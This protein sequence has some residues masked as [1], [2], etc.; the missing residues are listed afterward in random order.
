VSITQDSLGRRATFH[1]RDEASSQSARDL[2]IPISCIGLRVGHPAYARTIVDVM[3]QPID[4]LRC[5][6]AHPLAHL[7]ATSSSR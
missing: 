5:A 3:Y 4:Y 7:G 1:V 6:Q 2:E